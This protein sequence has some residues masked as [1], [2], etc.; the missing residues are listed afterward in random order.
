MIDYRVSLK[1]SGYSDGIYP[2]DAEVYFG[3]I[4]KWFS[5]REQAQEYV[6]TFEDWEQNFLAIKEFPRVLDMPF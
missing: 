6:N 5:T 3:D 1:S 4:C 2:S